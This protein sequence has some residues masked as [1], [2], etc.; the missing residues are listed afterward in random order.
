MLLSVI[1]SL[2]DFGRSAKLQ[3][4]IVFTCRSLLSRTEYGGFRFRTL[5]GGWW[6]V[7]INV[8]SV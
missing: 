7:I 1:P 2:T 8:I 4:V 6:G 5:L 3:L